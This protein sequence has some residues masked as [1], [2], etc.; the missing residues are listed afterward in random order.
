MAFGAIK[1]PKIF[2]SSQEPQPSFYEADQQKEEQLK[3]ELDPIRKFWLERTSELT[4]QTYELVI[5]EPD[6]QDPGKVIGHLN[7]FSNYHDYL[8]ALNRLTPEQL[9]NLGPDAWKDHNS[10]E[11]WSGQRIVNDQDFKKRLAEGDLKKYQDEYNH[12]VSMTLD[13]RTADEYQT[14]AAAA[15]DPVNRAEFEKFKIEQGNIKGAEYRDLDYAKTELSRELDFVIDRLLNDGLVSSL[16]AISKKTGLSYQEVE[17]IYQAQEENIIA[18]AKSEINK[19]TSLKKKIALTAAKSGIYIGAGILAGTTTAAT[20]GIGG[21]VGA[22]VIAGARIIDRFVT[23]KIGQNKL[24]K[25][26]EEIKKAKTGQDKEAIKNRF[27]AALAL[28]KELQIRGVVVGDRDKS[29]GKYI[30]EYITKRF[31]ELNAAGDPQADRYYGR[32]NVSKQFDVFRSLQEIDEAN[33]AL[34]DKINKPTWFDKLKKVEDKLSGA[35]V[36]KKTISTAALIGVGL[37]A[38]QIPGVRQVLAGY[39][40]WKLGGLAADLTTKK[41]ERKYSTDHL[42]FYLQGDLNNY[43]YLEARKMLLDKELQKKN[44]EAVL[45]LSKKIQEFEAGRINKGVLTAESA[46]DYFEK[47][48]KKDKNEKRLVNVLRFATRSAGAVLGVALGELAHD[49]AHHFSHNNQTGNS[50][51]PD[52]TTVDDLDK[53]DENPEVDSDTVSD[54][55]TV[56]RTDTTRVD[57]T[58]FVN[59]EPAVPSGE[60]SGGETNTF[61]DEISNVGLKVGQTDSVWRSTEQIFNDHAKELGYQGDLNNPDELHQWAEVQTAKAIN[62]TS[63]LDDKVFEGNKVVLEKDADGNYSVRVEEGSGYKPGSLETG[64]QETE[65]NYKT[66]ETKIDSEEIKTGSDNLASDDFTPTNRAGIAQEFSNIKRSELSPELFGIKNNNNL[67]ASDLQEVALNSDS[68]VEQINQDSD[69]DLNK[70]E[71]FNMFQTQN[72]GKLNP[73]AFPDDESITVDNFSKN[74]KLSEGEWDKINELTDRLHEGKRIT[75]ANLFSEFEK[76]KGKGEQFTNLEKM[77]IK[78][79]F[80]DHHDLKHEE[81][82]QKIKEIFIGFKIDKK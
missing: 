68:S 66:E 43:D 19:E 50:R 31:E 64:D 4:K 48:L 47:T 46:N 51:N 73:F 49:L 18:A 24:D 63:D 72:Q 16:D 25:K 8:E 17:E 15:Q 69:D 9:S 74:V 33:Q 78:N 52:K 79:I 3:E 27:V 13:G 14:V 39:A 75:K 67:E 61:T 20:L 71:L 32:E 2:K 62:N 59:Q 11:A 58:Q 35:T 21:V 44:P 28:K 76:I 22:S 1:F 30:G 60:I 82:K 80:N 40:G 34:E 45:A 10:G 36:E 29:T 41:A 42:E 12:F 23:E 37:A 55:D 65:S 53:Q 5:T 57:T 6:P 81:L 38:R 56:Q 77:Q 54:A 7:Q 70:K 26:V